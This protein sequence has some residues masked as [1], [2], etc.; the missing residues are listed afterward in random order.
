MVELV[1]SVAIDGPAGSGKS[2]V[3]KRIAAAKGY[4]YVDTGAMYRAVAHK[5]MSLDMNLEDE[6]AMAN[7]ARNT[8]IGFDTTGSKVLLDGVDVS[9]EIRSPEVARNVKYA[10]RAPDVRRLLVARQQE[11]SRKRP[12]V[13]EGRDITTVVLPHARYKFF[14]TASPEVRA[15]RR[16]AEMSEV[17]RKVDL[18]GILEDIKTRDDSDYKVG[19]MKEARDRALAGDGIVLLDT[20]D[21]TETQV[22]EKMLASME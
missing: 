11:M 17:G 4:L 19:P 6:A 1:D 18:A 20:S 10:A 9:A 3:A 8:D 14:L 2:S 22:V 21:L 12:V 13:M 15:E 16:C 7:L 5:A